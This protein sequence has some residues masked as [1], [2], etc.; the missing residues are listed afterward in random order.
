MPITMRLWNNE[1]IL[2]H[3]IFKT[4]KTFQNHAQ[5]TLDMLAIYYSAVLCLV[6]A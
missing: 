1:Q 5:E 3:I 2:N 6:S 4:K